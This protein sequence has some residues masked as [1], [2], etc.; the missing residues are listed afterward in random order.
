M[1]PRPMNDLQREAMA[2]AQRGDFTL[3][4][5]IE[6][7]YRCRARDDV[8]DESY[9][10]GDQALAG[11]RIGGRLAFFAYA[12]DDASDPPRFDADCEHCSGRGFYRTEDFDPKTDAEALMDCSE[13]SGSGR[14][15]DRDACRGESL[16]IVDLQGRTID[17]ET[18][19]SFNERAAEWVGITWAD[20]VLAGY[21]YDRGELFPSIPEQLPLFVAA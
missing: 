21:A 1:K 15:I 20:G 10:H 5:A 16:C 13:C 7:Q 14:V 11:L 8:A 3:A 2:L 12:D 9:E 17:T 19:L 4:D 18:E 6:V